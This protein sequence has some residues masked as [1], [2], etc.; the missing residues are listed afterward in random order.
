VRGLEK[1]KKVQN[2]MRCQRRERQVVFQ[3]VLFTPPPIPTGL[4]ESSRN[5]TGVL[6]DSRIPTGVLLDLLGVQ[7]E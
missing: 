6:V 5:P 3:A 7:W 1:G 2:I 4:Q